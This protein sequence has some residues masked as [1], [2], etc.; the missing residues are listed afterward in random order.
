MTLDSF[1][2]AID[3]FF[4]ATSFPAIVLFIIGAVLIAYTPYDGVGFVL[5]FPVVVV[6]AFMAVI[7]LPLLWFDDMRKRL[8]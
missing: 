8:R 3:N 7:A 4:M 2:E 6:Y 5:C 1:L